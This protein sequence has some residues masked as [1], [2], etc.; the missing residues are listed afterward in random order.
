ML[1]NGTSHDETGEARCVRGINLEAG[2][3]MDSVDDLMG[4]TYTTGSEI[5][6][7]GGYTL[8]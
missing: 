6:S 4:P 7:D 1:Q 3:H 5:I 8:W 2:G